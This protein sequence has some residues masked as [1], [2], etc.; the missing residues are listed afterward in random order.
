MDGLENQYELRYEKGG[1]EF[2]LCAEPT[3]MEVDSDPE[4][5]NPAFDDYMVGVESM[6][7]GRALSSSASADY[8]DGVE[9]LVVQTAELVL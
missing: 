1:G 2:P 9:S 8:M 4:F 7:S 5:S 3:P 6:D